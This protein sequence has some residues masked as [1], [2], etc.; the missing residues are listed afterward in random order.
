MDSKDH[1]HH[2]HFV[3]SIKKLARVFLLISVIYVFLL[4]IIFSYVSSSAFQ[5]D[6]QLPYISQTESLLRKQRRQVT[7]DNSIARGIKREYEQQY[8]PSDLNRI[9]Q[10]VHQKLRRDHDYETQ[11]NMPYDI[12]NCPSAPPENYP[13][14]WNAPDL[15]KNWNPG[16]TTEPERLYQS[17]CVFD[18]EQDFEKATTYRNAEV[19]FLIRNTPELLQ[20]AERWNHT[21]YLSKLL[22]GKEEMVE[23]A[24][25]PHFMYFKTGN[26]NTNQLPKGWKPPM[27]VNHLTFDDWYQRAH[28]VT[29]DEFHQERYYFRI[30]G[31]P[32]QHQFLLDELPIFDATHGSG[33]FMVDPNEARGINCRFGMKGVMA[34]THYDQSRNFIVL[35]GGQRRYVLAHPNQCPKMYLYPVGHPSGR[36]SAIDWI[37]PDYERFPEFAK[38]QLSEVVLQAGDALYLPTFWFHFIVSLNVNYQCNARSGATYEHVRYIEQCGFRLPR[39]F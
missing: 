4:S 10:Y 36:H 19:P 34:E 23:H 24:D 39:N 25:N 26:R 29:T 11:L 2:S 6:R 22:Q 31:G 27:E 9:K 1:N 17:L 12:Y 32:V 28:A 30:N 21:N 15:L 13:L 8:P 5:N 35:M 16:N 7:K 14:A 33:F 3:F 37:Q 18:Y 20:T 38:A